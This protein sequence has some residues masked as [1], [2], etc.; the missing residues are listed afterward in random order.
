MLRPQQY[1]W[2]VH[3]GSWSLT[4]WLRYVIVIVAITVVANYVGGG[5]Q[6]STV[7]GGSDEVRHG[8]GKVLDAPVIGFS[9]GDTIRVLQDGVSKR[10][11]LWGIDCPESNQ[12]FGTRAKQF[13]GDLAFGKAVTIRVHDVDRYGRQVA[14]IILPDGRNLNH[15]IVRAGFAWWYWQYARRDGELEALE[16]EAKAAKRGLWVD[17]EPVAPWEWRNG[18]AALR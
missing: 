7:L 10:I 2:R 18:S 9:D 11:R 15:E 17:K 3:I 1:K 4:Q 12:A 16:A 8:E 14:E 13:T 5:E 6:D